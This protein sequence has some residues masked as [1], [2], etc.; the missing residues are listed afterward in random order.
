MPGDFRTLVDELTL[1][2][3]ES[4]GAI[5]VALFD[6]DG[7]SV[8]LINSNE[9]T[10]RIP[11][12]SK[13]STPPS[14]IPLYFFDTILSAW[15]ELGSAVLDRSGA[16]PVYVGNVSRF[17]VWN[18][19]RVITEVSVMGCVE[20]IDGVRIDNARVQI[21]GEDY[22]GTAIAN[23]DS[24]G[25]FNVLAKSNSSVFIFAEVNGKKTNTI[26]RAT[27]SVD[28]SIESCLR[29]GDVSV[30]I[31]LTWGDG[32][33]DLDSHLVGPNYHVYFNEKGSL[34]SEPFAQLDVDDT[35]S[36][37][38][39]VVT[40]NKFS[41]AGTYT[42]SVYNYSGT[43]SP[44]I[45]TSPAKVELNINGAVTL[46]TPPPGE[47]GNFTWLVFELMVD[48]LGNITV[49]PIEQWSSIRI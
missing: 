36:F 46:F 13:N 19:D 18:A 6:A 47:A 24:L 38:P 17:Q 39:E 8:N 26:K 35:N 11:M 42:Y 29:L 32:P 2:A 27:G 21:I 1:S 7:N 10:I 44:S 30:S 25:E 20:D 34:D 28:L 37:G 9:A 33:S 16:I 12:V 14:I 22:I 15:I 40:I 31:T 48:E 3:L 41:V 5:S 43:V 23:T 45:T 49:N 4:F